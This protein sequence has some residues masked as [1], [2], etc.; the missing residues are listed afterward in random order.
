MG[1]QHLERHFYVHVLDCTSLLLPKANEGRLSQRM[2]Y[3][4]LH[5]VS[6]FKE[7]KAI[8]SGADG[9]YALDYVGPFSVKA[10]LLFDLLRKNGLK[11]IVVDSGAYPVPA[12]SMNRR[13]LL[14]KI[15]TAFRHNTFHLHLNALLIKALTRILPDQT[16]D[17]ALVSGQSWQ[18]DPRFGSA[19]VKIPAHSFDYEKFM[20]L[21]HK[22]PLRT[23]PYA[24]YLD[25]DI[26]GH[27]DNAEMG[28]SAPTSK[29][30][31]FPQITRFFEEFERNSGMPV[32][33]AGYPSNRSITAAHLSNH[34]IVYGQTAE[35]VRDATLV[36]AHAST[37]CS[38]AVLW[39]KPLVFITNSEIAASWYQPWIEVIADLLQ[40][41][42]V[43]LDACPT[44]A[45]PLSDWMIFDK[46]SYERYEKKYIKSSE[47]PDVSLWD[48]VLDVT[49]PPR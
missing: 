4:N 15:V 40:A 13:S 16:P 7:I 1:I 44:F 41:S 46:N 22:P 24:V 18:D 2:N 10:V 47:S 34:E 39:K 26:V 30:R 28:L 19:K 5:L 49:H 21:R 33:I 35:L 31:F 9:G 20:H 27:E 6:S 25:E 42:L 3:A 37:A 36:F 29:E 14:Q 12:T 45:I 23:V 17:F 11:L 48:R 8:L 43:D 38:F 32:V